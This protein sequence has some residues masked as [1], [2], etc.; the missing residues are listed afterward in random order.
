MAKNCR[1]QKRMVKPFFFKAKA[2]TRVMTKH[3]SMTRVAIHR[4]DE[5]IRLIWLT[6]PMRKKV[7]AKA[8]TLPKVYNMQKEDRFHV[9]A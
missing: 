9:K 3:P 6:G 7:A 1:M 2:E 8:T 4:L 5:N